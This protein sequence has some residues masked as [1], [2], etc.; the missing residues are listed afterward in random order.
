MKTTADILIRD[1]S[2]MTEQHLRQAEALKHLSPDLLNRKP[3]PES[4]SALECMEHLNLYGDFYLPAIAQN[5]K[6]NRH[7]A[8]S[9]LFKSRLLGN[10]FAQS[11]LP[12]ENMKKLKTF[13]D[14]DPRGSA[15]NLATLERFVEQQRSILDLLHTARQVDLMKAKVPLSLTKMLK[16][17]LGDAFRVVI[18]H[19]QRHLVQA[20]RAVGEPL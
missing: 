16:L 15:L 7:T 8:S 3:T 12:Q 11:M 6:N 5:I 4:W 9:Q 20:E 14:K 13:K 1:L 2:S 18:Y 19:N 17:K 10:Y